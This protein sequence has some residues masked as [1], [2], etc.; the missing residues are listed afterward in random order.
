[1]IY[2]KNDLS[3]GNK[4]ILDYDTRVYAG[5]LYF[6]LKRKNQ[7][8]LKYRLCLNS[9]P[10]SGRILEIGCG[11]GINLRTLKKLRPD[12]FYFGCDISQN[13]LN[14]AK[15]LDSQIK[16]LNQDLHSIRYNKKMDHIIIIDVLE[17]V[18]DINKAI[19]SIKKAMKK[20]ATMFINIPCEDSLLYNLFTMVD[21][22]LK[23]KY[24][25]HIRKYS[26]P[27]VISMLKNN[28]F[29][30]ENI[31]YNYHIL[32]QI[33]DLLKYIL[34]DF[35]YKKNRRNLEEGAFSLEG[36]DIILGIKEEKN[37]FKLCLKKSVKLL[38]EW[39]ETISYYESII[40]RNIGLCAIGLNVTAR[41]MDKKEDKGIRK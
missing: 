20:D 25:G 35:A 2:V 40:L 22:D 32:G 34:M 14:I 39:L 41:L 12:L 13:S 7:K 36:W 5:G 30:I 11:A 6:D 26:K 18:P 9:L 3:R 10:K 28:G 21:Y 16:Y 19:K 24:G 38:L 4:F 37:L 8:T 1:M 31:K 23:K 33:R 17:H 15:S 27:E 29:V